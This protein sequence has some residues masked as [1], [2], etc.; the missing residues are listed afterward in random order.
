M[1]ASF[2][3]TKKGLVPADNHFHELLVLQE[4]NVG[5]SPNHAVQVGLLDI[6]VNIKPVHGFQIS[7][8][9]QNIVNHLNVCVSF[10]GVSSGVAADLHSGRVEWCVLVL[11]RGD[12]D[13]VLEPLWA[14]L[15]A[16]AIKSSLFSFLRIS[17]AQLVEN[18]TFLPALEDPHSRREKLA[19]LVHVPQMRRAEGEESMEFIFVFFKSREGGSNNQPSKTVANEGEAAELRA[20]TGLSNVLVNL[21]C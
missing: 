17:H 14:L 3:S 11:V 7:A 10:L 18:Y 1:K 8:P 16:Q 19:S 4:K 15:L 21:L 12:E 6:E 13:D 5:G 9:P 2:K 20:W